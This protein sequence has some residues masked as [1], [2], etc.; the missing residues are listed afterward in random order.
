MVAVRNLFYE[1]FEDGNVPR[2]NVGDR[3]AGSSARRGHGSL[4]RQFAG[5]AEIRNQ[6]ATRFGWLFLSAAWLG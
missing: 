3:F 6:R 2:R 5:K 1:N 4:L